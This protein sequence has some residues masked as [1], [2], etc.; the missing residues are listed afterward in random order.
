MTLSEIASQLQTALIDS[1]KAHK[2]LEEAKAALSPLEDAA[3]R[4]DDTVNALMSQYQSATGVSAPAQ[5]KKRGG[6]GG[7]RGPRS[8]QAIAMTA[9]SRLLGEEHKAGRKKPQ[10]I[11]AALRSEERR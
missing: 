9:A 5:T 8:F 7:T 2:A 6:K 1:Q 11:N 4:A 3:S 10:A